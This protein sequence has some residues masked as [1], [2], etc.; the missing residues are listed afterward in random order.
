VEVPAGQAW[1]FTIPAGVSHAYRGHGPGPMVMVA[2]NS[3]VHDPA[4]PPIR[5]VILP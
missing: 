3:E 1:R 2:F 5:D 4:R